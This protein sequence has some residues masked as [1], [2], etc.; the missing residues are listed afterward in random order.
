MFTRTF[1]MKEIE[2]K[3]LMVARCLIV[4]EFARN[5][6][7]SLRVSMK[8]DK[9]QTLGD[10]MAFQPDELKKSVWQPLGVFTR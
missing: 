6:W 10:H 2:K 4:I 8:N 3:P 1:H 5:V 7:Q 9:Q